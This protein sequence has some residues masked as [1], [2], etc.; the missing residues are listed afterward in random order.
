[1]TIGFYVAGRGIGVS[2]AIARLAFSAQNAV[3]P[4]L[5]ASSEYLS[6]FFAGAGNP[7]DNYLVFL[8]GGL[9]LGSLI[10][11][12]LGK[13]LGVK[14][15]RGPRINVSGRLFFALA[16]GVFVGFGTRLAR[17]CSSG[18]ALVGGSELSVGAF[19]F[20]FAVFAGGFLTAYFVRRQWL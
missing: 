13:E 4:G 11:A 2:G 12:I 3:A 1:M 17:G 16:G 18:L 8:L 10:S 19:A 15:L 14:V 9:A 5:T 6:A 20:M 7:L